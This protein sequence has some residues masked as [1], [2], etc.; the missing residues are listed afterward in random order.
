MADLRCPMCG[1]NNPPQAET[2]QY[3]QARLKSVTPSP[4]EGGGEADWLRDLRDDGVLGEQPQAPATPAP[5]SGQEPTP[6]SI[7]E[8]EMPDWLSRI[9]QRTSVEED[10]LSQIGSAPKIEEDLTTAGEEV[11]DWLRDLPL[12]GSDSS[13]IPAWMQDVR[14]TTEESTAPTTFSQPA[15]EPEQPVAPATDGNDAWLQSLGAWDGQPQADEALPSQDFTSLPVEEPSLAEAL[16]AEETPDWLKSL[17]AETTSAPASAAQDDQDWIKALEALSAET[18]STIE[19]TIQDIP[20]ATPVEN[21]HPS[22][23]TDFLHTLEEPPSAPA[24]EPSLPVEASQAPSIISDWP[25]SAEQAAPPSTPPLDHIPS[26]GVTEWLDAL[27]KAETTPEKAPEGAPTSD[28][29]KDID[30]FS[31]PPAEPPAPRESAIASDDSGPD[32]LR[33]FGNI[34]PPLETPLPGQTNEAVPD[35]LTAFG[36]EDTAEELPVES[37]P[38]ETRD[39]LPAESLPEWLRAIEPQQPAPGTPAFAGSDEGKTVGPFSEEETSTWISSSEPLPAETEAYELPAFTVETEEGA[40]EQAHPLAEGE[41]LPDWIAAEP[42]TAVESSEENGEGIEQAQL[43]TWL[44]AMRPLE[45]AVQSRATS[46][47]EER[48]EK[49]GPLAGMS[50]VLPGEEAVTQYRKP[51]IYSARLRVSDKQ[52]VLA[53]LLETVVAEETMT[54]PLQA[55]PNQAPQVIIRLLVGVVLIA[56]LILSLLVKPFIGLPKGQTAVGSAANQVFKQIEELPASAPVLVVVDYEAGLS[57]EMKTAALPVIQHL[58]TRKARLVMVSTQPVGVVLAEDLLKDAATPDRGSAITFSVPQSSANLGYLVGGAF[59]LRELAAP[60]DASHPRPLQSALPAP[61]RADGGWDGL[62]LKSL[63][64]ITDFKRVILLTDSIESGRNW[65]EQVQPALAK[66]VPLLVVSSAQAAPL[67][68]P[69]QSSGQVNAM[70]SGLVG[71]RAYE[72]I[73]RRPAAASAYWNAYQVGLGIALLLILLG[74]IL[75]SLSAL[76]NRS[77]KQNQAKG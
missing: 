31:A 2:C 35:W 23:L 50:G 48:I 11:P 74:G 51:P 59:S 7:P 33:D 21:E 47:D 73:T 72:E 46:L 29:L 53:N 12:D 38:S 42:S 67:L 54:Q 40:I 57:G 65:L 77:K 63:S 14:P 13:S 44:Q 25:V 30:A 15:I 45:A 71:G 60:M 37:A 4:S 20:P 3:C 69:F 76:F 27:E 17:E 6:G 58:M 26:A 18:P 62:V 9:R 64:Q 41:Q 32:W 36:S 68:Q 34:S 24:E 1:K 43:P 66:K 70:L 8:G 52:Q 55:E 16:P 5:F 56:A 39:I 19:N 22:G 28:W 10:A 61:L 49:S 75:M